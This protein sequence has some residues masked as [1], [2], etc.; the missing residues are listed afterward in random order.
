LRLIDATMLWSPASGGVRRYLAVKHAWLGRQ[1]GVV[2]DLV[3]PGEYGGTATDDPGLIRFPAPPLPRSEGYR[4]PVRRHAIARLLAARRPDLI[5]V[6]DPYTMAWSALEAA[7]R[8]SIPCVAYCHSDLEA[9]ARLAGGRA[10]GSLAARAARAYARG[11]YRRFDAVFAGSRH[12]ASRLRELGVERV[13]MQPLGVDTL[14]F[15]PARASAAWRRELGFDPRSRI[16]VYAGRFAAEKHLD[17]LAAAVER[18]GAP[19]TLL[20][21][22]AGRAAPHG[23]RVRRLPF[24]PDAAELAVALASSDAFVHAGDQETFGLSALEAMA[25][26][27]PLVVRASAGLAELVDPEVGEAVPLGTAAAFAEAI[28][29]LFARDATPL[30]QS[31]RARAESF[32]W[33]S[34]LRGLLGHYGR[35]VAGHDLALQAAGHARGAVR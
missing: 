11:L 23:R 27:T 5:E 9:L 26:G 2:H 31:A 34:T 28:D 12:M 8:L 17:V 22:G 32:A 30:R 15:H 20:L 29:A 4:F 21:I 25:C 16:L 3:V 13:L 19:Y 35:I 33:E 14:V 7:R 6:G 10:L 24:V 1:Q 18:L